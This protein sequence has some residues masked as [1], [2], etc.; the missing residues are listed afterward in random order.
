MEQSTAEDV[1]QEQQ[2][3]P[4]AE[5]T[6]ESAAETLQGLLGQPNS[7]EPDPKGQPEG[8]EAP[9]VEAEQ[10]P[11]EE[12]KANPITLKIGE[13][14]FSIPVKDLPEELRDVVK[15]GLLMRADYTRKTQE[16]AEG[17][18]FVEA[19]VQELGQTFQAMQAMPQ[20]LAALSAIDA[21]LQQF[22]Q[23]NWQRFESEDPLGAIQ[24]K[25]KFQ[26]L[27]MQRG[28]VLGTLQQAHQ[29]VTAYQQKQMQERMQ[30]AL[31]KVREAIPDFGPEKAKALK[32]FGKSIGYTDAQLNS[33]VDAPQLIALNGLYEYSKVQKQAKETQA[34]VEKL[35]PKQA[36]SGTSQGPGEG[37]RMNQAAFDRLRSGGRVEDAGAALTSLLFAKK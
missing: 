21:Q 7:A 26:D 17:R 31:P 16:V 34:K 13:K 29:H 32:E 23:V 36:K 5:G 6:I 4:P 14:E 1:K 3:D 35:P 25:Q 2:I 28:H 27:Q 18:K 10:A 37:P 12:T 33:I 15:D 30:A 19:K 11:V 8:E 24:A 20:Q 9:A 22:G